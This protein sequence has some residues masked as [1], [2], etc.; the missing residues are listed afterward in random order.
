M[1][2]LKNKLSKTLDIS[3]PIKKQK[4]DIS[5]LINVNQVFYFFPTIDTIRNMSTIENSSKTTI[6][7]L[8]R[9]NEKKTIR[10]N[11]YTDRVHR[12]N[13]NKRRWKITDNRGGMNHAR[14][15]EYYLYSINH[16]I[17]V[18]ERNPSAPFSRFLSRILPI[19][20][21]RISCL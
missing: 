4:N 10:L 21:A 5:V 13:S 19:H 18:S 20:H 3:K 2:N 15:K 1:N 6:T 16:S 17:S 8:D 12:L 11:K 14:R 7:Q 9:H